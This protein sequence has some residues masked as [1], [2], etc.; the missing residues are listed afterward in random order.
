MDSTS[1]LRTQLGVVPGLLEGTGDDVTAE[2]STWTP[3]GVA[4]PLA[5]TYAHALSAEDFIVNAVLR[6]AAP[7]VADGWSGR[8][9][10]SEPPPMPPN[11][12]QW[13]REA[14]FD[15]PALRQYAKA[16]A[17]STEEYLASMKPEDLDRQIDMP[18][19]GQRDVGWLLNNVV[20]THL[21]SHCGEI[22]CLKGLQGARGYPF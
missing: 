16:V 8:S 13:A 5:A 17:A 18:M 3:P 10:M 21:A 1:L 6:G 2:Q 15:L 9:G 7:L 19:F 4:N 14:R 11:W 20:L 12:A 22:A